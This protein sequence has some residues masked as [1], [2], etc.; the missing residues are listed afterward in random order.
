MTQHQRRP[1]L[2]NNFDFQTKVLF[3]SELN[4]SIV[5]VLLLY[6]YIYIYKYKTS[7]SS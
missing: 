1:D 7:R 6:L 4:G 2:I 3:E 5:Y